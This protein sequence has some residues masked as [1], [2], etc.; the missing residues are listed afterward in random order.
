VSVGVVDERFLEGGPPPFRF[1]GLP[2]HLGPWGKGS[3]S[4]YS[5]TSAT[6]KEALTFDR[7]WPLSSW[8][9]LGLNQ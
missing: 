4:G 2:V 3:E 6:L 1:A 9:I 5:G 8:A 7:S